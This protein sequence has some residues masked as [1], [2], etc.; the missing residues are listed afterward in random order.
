MKKYDELDNQGRT[1]DFIRLLDAVLHE[2]HKV[3]LMVA[4]NRDILRA[5]NW[6]GENVLHWLAVENHVEGISLLRSLGS[7]IPTW[8]LVEAVEMGNIE[9]VILL[10]ELGVEVEF[11]YC[12]NA[13]EH[14]SPNITPKKIRL[15]KSYFKQFGY[16]M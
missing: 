11:S 7:P 3:P 10:L 16:E 15:M 6:I 14:K 1:Y 2:P 9:T 5:T 12:R 4:E 13:L 8:A